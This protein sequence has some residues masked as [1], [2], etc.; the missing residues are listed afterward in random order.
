MTS[1]LRLALAALLAVGSPAAGGAQESVL[2]RPIE[3]EGWPAE[4]TRRPLTLAESMFEVTVP[5]G[6]GL[7]RDR[8]GK[9]VTLSPS[10]YYGVSD[11]LTVGLRHFAGLCL[12]GTPDCPRVYEDLSVDTLWRLWRGVSTDLALGVALN[13]SPITDPLALSAEARLL[14]RFR[15]GPAALG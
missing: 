11:G 6:I 10:I 2:D 14:G 9:P 4:I 15:A 7:S 3:K 5:L 12:S 8:G 1:P 13:A